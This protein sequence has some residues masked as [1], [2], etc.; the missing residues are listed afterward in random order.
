MTRGKFSASRR[1]IEKGVG[2]R[3]RPTRRRTVT[4]GRVL[5]GTGDGGDVARTGRPF[6]ISC[7]SATPFATKGATAPV[8]GV[9][10]TPRI[11]GA[12]LP[13]GSGTLAT[14]TVSIR[15]TVFGSHGGPVGAIS[16]A[17]STPACIA[18]AG[19]PTREPPIHA[20]AS[21]S[22]RSPNSPLERHSLRSSCPPQKRVCEVEQEE[23]QWFQ[24]EFGLGNGEPL[25]RKGAVLYP[26]PRQVL[27]RQYPL[28][29]PRRSLKEVPQKI[30]WVPKLQVQQPTE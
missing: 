1:L 16:T 29:L 15:G 23:Y 27:G 13:R 25:Q 17:S 8:T 12:A 24:W 6:T 18:L 20:I 11:S 26:C 14:G 3:P 30:A 10:L 9:S 21:G 2:I 19:L 5:S 4:D 22:K 7:C 28:L